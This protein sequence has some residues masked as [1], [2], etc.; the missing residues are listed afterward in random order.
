MIKL[1]IDLL[2]IIQRTIIVLQTSSNEYTFNKNF[3]Y[4]EEFFIFKENINEN[5]RFT[6]DIIANTVHHNKNLKILPKF[7]YCWP[8]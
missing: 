6:L 7:P 3:C 8:F 2:F 5:I 1:K 4:K